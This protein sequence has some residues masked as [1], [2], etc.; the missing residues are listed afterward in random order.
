MNKD[1][2]PSYIFTNAKM[3]DY[4][5]DAAK[6]SELDSVAFAN[7]LVIVNSIPDGDAY[8]LT[9]DDLAKALAKY[10]SKFHRDL[11]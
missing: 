6:K 5:L 7:S 3:G 1:D 2:K 11:P 4:L 8:V 9:R 10:G